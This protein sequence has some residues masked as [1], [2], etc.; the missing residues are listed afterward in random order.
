[1]GTIVEADASDLRRRF[2]RNER[3]DFCQ[4]NGGEVFYTGQLRSGVLI[5]DS[6]QV[7]RNLRA[8]ACV[9]LRHGNY[10]ARIQHAGV[11]FTCV[12]ELNQ[13]HLVFFQAIA[14]AMST[15]SLKSPY[16]VCW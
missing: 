3:D 5:N 12:P 8:Q 1:M 6:Q 2:V 15:A 10:S 9:D 4:W 16:A 11:N 13:F 7:V 14:S